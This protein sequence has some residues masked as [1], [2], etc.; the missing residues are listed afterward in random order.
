MSLESPKSIESILEQYTH[1]LKQLEIPSVLTFSEVRSPYIS[2]LKL[3]RLKND[4]PNLLINLNN[5]KN[6]KNYD[7]LRNT[8][9]SLSN[10]IDEKLYITKYHLKKERKTQLV[11]VK[12]EPQQLQ[13][14]LLNEEEDLNELRQRLIS[15]NSYSNYTTNDQQNDYHESI[16]DDL[17]KDLTSLASSLKNSALSLSNK[18]IDDTKV[19]SKTSDNLYQNESLMKVVGVNLNNYLLNKSSGKISIWFLIKV[20]ISIFLLFLIMILLIKILPKM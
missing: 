14:P 12:E 1:E 11:E 17:Y 18:I 15:D 9:V 5:F 8:I 3:N 4:L 6:F 16:Q 10:E 7:R 2:Q 19:L 13:E 20:M